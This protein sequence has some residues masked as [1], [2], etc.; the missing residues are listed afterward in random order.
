[1]KILPWFAMGIKYISETLNSMI[2]KHIKSVLVSSKSISDQSWFNTLDSKYTLSVCQIFTTWKHWKDVPLL[3]VFNP[4]FSLL[5]NSHSFFICII[6][7]RKYTIQFHIPIL[8]PFA[9]IQRS[10]CQ[11]F[12]FTSLIYNIQIFIIWHYAF[13]VR[14]HP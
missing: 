12:P 9:K 7:T 2:S 3:F 1:M 13:D 6:H 11:L 5:V 14:F 8:W 10:T 4:L